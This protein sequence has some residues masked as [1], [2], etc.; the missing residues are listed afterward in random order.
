[1][2]IENPLMRMKLEHYKTKFEKLQRA[3]KERVFLDDAMLLCNALDQA[4]AYI[5]VLIN[6]MNER[7]RDET[8]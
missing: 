7:D 1:M 5:E 6:Q 4:A 8:D 3:K 2:I